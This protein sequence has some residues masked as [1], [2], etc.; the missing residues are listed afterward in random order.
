MFLKKYLLISLK[1][2]W[3]LVKRQET[4]SV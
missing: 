3:D 1:D 2:Y 4:L